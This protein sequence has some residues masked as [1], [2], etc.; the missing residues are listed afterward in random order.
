MGG[1]SVHRPLVPSG[2]AAREPIAKLAATIPDEAPKATSGRAPTTRPMFVRVVRYRFRDTHLT[3][4]TA[5]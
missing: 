1:R 3:D 2:A 5:S 4:K